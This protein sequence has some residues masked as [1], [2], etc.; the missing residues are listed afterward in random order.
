[1]S[2]EPELPFESDPEDAGN[3]SGAAPGA[4]HVATLSHDGRFWDVYVEFDDDP[5]RTDSFGGLLCFS[6]AAADGAVGGQGSVRTATILIESSYEEVLHRA[7][8]FENQHMVS[9]LRSCLPDPT[10]APSEEPL[11]DE[12]LA[13]DTG[14]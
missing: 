3:P 5:R 12:P 1:M 11:G 8:Q 6:P 14:T 10:E 9:L 2:T 13:E 4:H 7:R